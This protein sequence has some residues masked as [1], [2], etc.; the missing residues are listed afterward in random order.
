MT[1][2]E[3]F[4]VEGFQHITD[5]KGIDHIIFIA[6]LTSLYLYSD[7]KKLLVLITAFTIGHSVTLALSSMNVMEF[8]RDTI[9]F[10]IPVT[11][12]VT[13]LYNIIVS[14]TQLRNGKS[15]QPMQV[16]YAMALVFGLIHGLG[17]SSYLKSLFG[18]DENIIVRLLSFNLGLEIGQLIIVAVLLFISFIFVRLLKLQQLYYIILINSAVFVIAV[19]MCIERF[20]F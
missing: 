9:E 17:F 19:R 2:F 4:F 8:N 12:L 6:A 16:V 5:I 11:I 10:L 7:W 15:T 13:A 18:R 1:D 20:P 14:S 3:L